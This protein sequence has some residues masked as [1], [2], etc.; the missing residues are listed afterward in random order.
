MSYEWKKWQA[1]ALAATTW[2]EVNEVIRRMVE[3]GGYGSVAAATQID[4]CKGGHGDLFPIEVD[5][6]T[7]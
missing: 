5:S 1:E 6:G 4:L 7:S 2:I 3:E